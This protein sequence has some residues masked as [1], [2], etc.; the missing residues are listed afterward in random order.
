MFLVGAALF[1]VAEVV[2][3]VLVGEHIGFGW[4]I[5]LLI[6][7]SLLGP[8]LV[9]R[10]GLGVLARTQDRLARGDLPTWELLDGVVVLAAGI[11][12][13]VPGFIS[14]AL[15]LLLLIGPIRRLVVRIGG[16]RVA[17]RVEVMRPGRWGVVDVQ[18]WPT[19]EAV[20]ARTGP[21]RSGPAPTGPAPTGPDPTPPMIAPEAQSGRS[22]T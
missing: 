9:K 4:A 6:G 15:G 12:I 19:D 18:T 3:F 22:S 7:V 13:C 17:R 11:M 5:L 10:V 1:F 20:P 2:A 8:M 21:A 16:R 14:D